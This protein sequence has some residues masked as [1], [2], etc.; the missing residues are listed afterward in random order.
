MEEGSHVFC[1]LLIV[2][3]LQVFKAVVVLTSYTLMLPSV[4]VAHKMS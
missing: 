1:A 3:V 2:L 4:F